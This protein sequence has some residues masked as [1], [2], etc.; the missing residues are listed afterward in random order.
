M[1]DQMKN[2]L[3][4]FFITFGL[5]IMVFLLLGRML[6]N[7]FK[8]DPSSFSQAAIDIFNA[9]NGNI[10]FK[11]WTSP[12]G[13]CYI[14]IFMYLF[15][16]LLSS[17][18]A[19]M[20]INRY[21]TVWINLDAYRRFTIIKLKNSVSYDKFIGA[22]T[23]TFFPINIIMLPISLVLTTLR[24]KRG[25]DIMLKIQYS[26]MMVFYCLMSA[27][28]LIPAAPILI[29][30]IYA[31]SVFIFATNKRETYKGENIMQML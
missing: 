9:F 12:I 23:L 2:E 19:A 1:L 16:I 28:L 14:T 18:L 25:S 30:K 10:E 21:Q 13:E 11:L 3:I 4:R 15:K 20:F 7:E 5:V 8:Y 29:F 26:V 17:L 22:V 24:S 31:N 27:F 6:S